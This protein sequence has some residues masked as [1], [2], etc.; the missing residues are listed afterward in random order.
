MSLENKKE[1]INDVASRLQAIIETAVDGIIAIND[2]GI[3]E[4]VNPAGCKIF[5]YAEEEMMGQNVSMLMPQPHSKNHDGYMMNYLTTGERKI[6]GIGREV[7]GRKKDGTIFPFWLAVSEFKLGERRMFTGV[8]HDMT[9]QKK[10][11]KALRELN[12]E[13]EGRISERTEKLSDVVNKLL[14]SNQQLQ[15][16]I[17]ERKAVAHALLLSREELQQTENLLQQIVYYFPDGAISVADRNLN[18]LFSGGEL[19]RLFNTNPQDVIGKRLFPLMSD[20]KWEEIKPLLNKVFEGESI[21]DFELPERLK[22]QD[23]VFDAVPLKESDGSINR[24]AIFMRA[25]T[26]LKKIE[27]ELRESLTKE[28]EL[29][30]LKSRFVAMA[31]HEFRTPLSTILSSASL[32][33]Q[34]IKAEQQDKRERHFHKIKSSVDILTTILNDFLSL[35]RLEEGKIDINTEDFEIHDFCRETIDDVKNILKQGQKI[36]LQHTDKKIDVHLDKKVLKLILFNLI[37]NASKYSDESTEIIFEIREKKRR[38]IISITDAGIGIPEEEQIH[39]FDRF[40]R[41]SNATAIKGTGLGLHI[42][43]R[44]AELM[45]GEIH[46]ESH[47]GKGSTFAVSFPTPC[48]KGEYISK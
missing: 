48:P 43:K 6:I 28:R 36:Q 39:L 5:G 18:Y 41:A 30:L 7:P 33:I 12:H 40:F 17:Q 20:E 37:S 16:E 11:E 24:I 34:Y 47:L 32:M 42:V 1:N 31:S 45:G 9:E 2:R 13:L 23:L 8:V 3:I 46:F 4:S 29:G 25:I 14:S 21:L 44:Y 26:K 27:G 10:A 35:S 15:H 38:L 19:H 22:N